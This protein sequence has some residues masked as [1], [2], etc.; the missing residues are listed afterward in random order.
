VLGDTEADIIRNI[1]VRE[2]VRILREVS[3]RP[4]IYRKRRRE[5]GQ[6]S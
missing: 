6:I 5:K 2:E 1:Q 4:K 3:D